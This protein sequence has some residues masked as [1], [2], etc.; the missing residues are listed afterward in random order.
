MKDNNIQIVFTKTDAIFGIFR[1]KNKSVVNFL[2]I[3]LKFFIFNMKCRNILP[4]FN[5]FIQYLKL[6]I[7]IEAQ[8]A[9]SHDKYESH[10]QKWGKIILN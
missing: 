3:L 10:I 7:K 6:R 1:H 2:I 9:V 4:T 8:I 5:A